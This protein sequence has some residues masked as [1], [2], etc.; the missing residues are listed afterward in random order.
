MQCPLACPVT[1]SACGMVNTNLCLRSTG[2]WACHR[3]LSDSTMEGS[4]THDRRLA[5]SVLQP[6]SRAEGA[7]TES[8]LL[9]ASQL[10]L[11]SIS[12]LCKLT[13]AFQFMLRACPYGGECTQVE[14]GVPLHCFCRPT[15]LPAPPA[16]TAKVEPCSALPALTPTSPVSP[17]LPTAPSA[18]ETTSAQQT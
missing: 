3:P 10:T 14:Y 18:P 4:V 16:L 2:R 9:G 15:V 5:C 8:C 1:P 12:M 11:E 6:V 17:V 7:D 13:G